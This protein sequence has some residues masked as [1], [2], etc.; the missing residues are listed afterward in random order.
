M[1]G[2]G[3][4]RVEGLPS[5][6]AN[7]LLEFSGGVRG[8]AFNLEEREIGCVVLG[9]ASGIEEGEEVK[10]TGE[11]LSVPVG[12]GFLGRVVD[13]LGRPLDGKGE[14][15]ADDRRPR[16]YRRRPCSGAGEGTAVHR[17]QGHRLHD[18]HR[19]GQRELIIGDRQTEDG[20]RDRR[21][22]Q[23]ARRLGDGRPEA[24][25][26]VHLRGDGPEGIHRSRGR[27]LAE[28]NGAMETRS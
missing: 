28:E 13:P 10:R 18:G 17:H 2:D 6:M 1:T 15:A 19:A 27:G 20:H 5:T 11:V 7:E 3:I 16:R 22:H 26:E 4:A 24:A 14:I 9:D 12:N 25:R 8:F 23:P 21:D